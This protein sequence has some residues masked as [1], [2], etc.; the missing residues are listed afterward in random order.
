M[1][2]SFGAPSVCGPK[3]APGYTQCREFPNY[4]GTDDFSGHSRARRRGGVF[5]ERC[6]SGLRVVRK[7]KR[8]CM[9]PQSAAVTAMNSS[10]TG[11]KSVAER[12]LTRHLHRGREEGGKEGR[13]CFIAWCQEGGHEEEATWQG[14]AETEIG[15]QR[16]R[17]ALTQRE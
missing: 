14:V 12:A 8:G 6:M 11:F 10:I 17:D 2:L 3:A 5:A 16:E 4:P 7:A 13:S 1:A 9:F 15:R